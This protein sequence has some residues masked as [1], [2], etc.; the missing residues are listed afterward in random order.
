MTQEK[1]LSLEILLR[2]WRL[3]GH[4]LRLNENSPAQKAMFNYFRNSANSKFKGR[5]RITLPYTL[6]LDIERTA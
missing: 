4:T 3:F 1:P 5:P 2:R 6:N